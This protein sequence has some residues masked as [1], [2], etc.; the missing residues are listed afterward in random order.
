MD[1]QTDGILHIQIQLRKKIS[2]ALRAEM[3]DG[4]IQGGG[5]PLDSI[6]LGAVYLVAVAL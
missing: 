1:R 3:F 2:L 4:I 5:V 6:K